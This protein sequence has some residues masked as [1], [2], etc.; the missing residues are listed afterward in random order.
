MAL[1]F[2]G[3]SNK[4]I[5]G[6]DVELL[7][8]AENT[9]SLGSGDSWAANAINWSGIDKTGSSLADLAVRNYSDLSGRPAD[10]D[11]N[12]LTEGTVL[13]DADYLAFFDSSISAYRKVSFAQ[14]SAEIEDDD[15]TRNNIPDGVTFVVKVEYQH[16]IYNNLYIAGDYVV[17]GESVVL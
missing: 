15:Q 2:G 7:R 9:L 8:S 4:I 1:E 11:F 14:L 12:T 10:D 6:G 13:E 3:S 5:F 16:L 17:N